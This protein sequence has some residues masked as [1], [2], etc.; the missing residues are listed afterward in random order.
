MPAKTQPGTWLLSFT[1]FT[2]APDSA[3]SPCRTVLR[4]ARKG[5]LDPER[6]VTNGLIAVNAALFAGQVA[7]KGAVTQW[8]VK[9]LRL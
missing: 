8:G 3:L 4:H 2:D 5:I 1:S 6:R 7:S 9:V